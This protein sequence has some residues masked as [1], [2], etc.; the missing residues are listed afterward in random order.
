MEN[1]GKKRNFPQ[2]VVPVSLCERKNFLTGKR[3]SVMDK[4]ISSFLSRHYQ[5]LTTFSPSRAERPVI[6]HRDCNS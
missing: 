1:I 5:S 3:Q 4:K 2:S 6:G